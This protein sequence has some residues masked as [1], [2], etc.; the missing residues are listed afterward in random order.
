MVESIGLLVVVKSILY[1]GIIAH[2]RLLSATKLEVT[3]SR[4]E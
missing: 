2:Y 4:Q 1:E 3:K